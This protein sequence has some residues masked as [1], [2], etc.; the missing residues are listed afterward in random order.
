MSTIYILYGTET[1]NSQGCAEQAGEAL[2]GRGYTAEVLDMD[3]FDPDNLP[4]VQVLLIVTSTFGDGEPPSNAEDLHAAL[5]DDDAPSLSGVNFSVCGLGDTSYDEF[6]QCAKDFDSRLAALGAKRFAPRQDCDVDFEEPFEAWLGQVIAGLGK[7]DLSADAAAPDASEYDESEYDESAYDESQYEESQYEESQY[8]ESQYDESEYDESEYEDSQYDEPAEVLTPPRPVARPQ[9]TARPRP[10][11]AKAPKEPEIGSRKNPFMS[12]IL[13]NHNLN[14]ADSDKET[15]HVALSLRGSGIDYKVGDALGLFPQNCPD[16][17]RWTLQ[18]VGLR[19]DEVVEVQGQAMTLLDAL[20][21]RLDII[22]IDAR[23]LK[24][25]AESRYAGDLFQ[26]IANSADARKEYIG[27]HH[28]GDLLSLAGIRP[29]AASF[30]AALKPLAPR[31]YSISSSPKAHPGEVH[32]TVDVV[33]Y[34]MYGRNR[35]GVSSS[36]LGERCPPGSRVPVYL[37]RSP[38]FKITDDDDAPIIM[39]GPGTGIA[40]FRAFLEEREARGAQGYNWLFFG[41][42]HAHCDYLYQEQV[43]RWY[44]S[45]LI[46]RL[47]L[48]FS[49]DQEHKIYVQDRILE[50]GEDFWEWIDADAHIYICGDA[51]R[52]AKDVHAALMKVIMTYGRYSEGDAKA[53]LKWMSKNGRYLKD[54]Y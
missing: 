51:S 19:G 39:I 32:L 13:V 47:D 21:H 8:E 9:P 40:P 49:R 10:T 43:E 38:N 18:N 16:L 50:N 1:F 41:A 33:R 36:F 54:V 48:A 42:R 30:A 17:V 45:G 53:L 26:P 14:G 20:T 34:H 28:V 5:M 3:D 35:K 11:P 2:T 4:H 6:C 44:Q 15:R 23:L 31:L 7:L 12:T 24:L 22:K 46:S 27:K 25:A 52:M 37:H 29:D